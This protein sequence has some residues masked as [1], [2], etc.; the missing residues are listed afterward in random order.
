M[1]A[2]INFYEEEGCVVQRGARQG[3][4]MK[5]LTKAYTLARLRHH[6]VPLLGTRRASEVTEGDIETFSRAVTN[7]KSAR[8][9]W[10]IDPSTGRKKHIIVRGGAGAARKV[11]RDLSAMFSFAGRHR[12]VADNPVAR[13]SV[14]KTDNQNERF[15]AL[16]E[17]KRLGAALEA[18]EAE[19]VNPK[20][21]NIARLWALTGFRRDEAAGLKRAEI[22]LDLGM[23]VFDQSKTGKSIRPLG[24]AAVALLES[25]LAES[26]PASEFLFP[27]ERGNSFYAGTKRIWPEIIK[28]AKLPDV[29]PHTLRHTIGGTAGSAG[30]ALLMIGAILGHANTR[31]TSIYAHVAHDPARMAADRVTAPIAAALSGRIASPRGKA[32]QRSKR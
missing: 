18:L 19:G 9:E 28:R 13:A 8:D 17:I 11:V 21:I 14:R 1:T 10:V 27:A 6:V 15:L 31:S 25:L 32:R 4:P 20:A 30:E 3:E 2:L 23:V 16:D 12:I 5:A 24:A 29:T 7:G 26:D 22:N